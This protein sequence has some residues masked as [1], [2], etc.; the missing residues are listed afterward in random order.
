MSSN[1]YQLKSLFL[2]WLLLRNRLIQWESLC[3]WKLLY[4]LIEQTSTKNKSFVVKF[5]RIWPIAEEI[6]A[7]RW[8]S[9]KKKNCHHR[10]KSCCNLFLAWFF[11]FFWFFWTRIPVDLSVPE[12]P[13]SSHLGP[14]QPFSHT[15]QCF[16]HPLILTEW[17]NKILFPLLRSLPCVV[18][19]HTLSICFI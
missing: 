15:V 13:G 2:L 18:N 14:L 5:L 19:M 10:R 6:I 4:P 8:N 16:G 7:E 9:R 3:C 1:L 17:C 12:T 11:C